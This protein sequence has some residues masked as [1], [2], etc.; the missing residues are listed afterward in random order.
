LSP[1]DFL[2]KAETAVRSARV[3]LEAD[4]PDGACNRAYYAM[5]DAAR[6]ALLTSSAPVH[7]EVARTH[8]GL[9]AAFGLHMVK[10]GVLD[11][12]LGRAFNRAQQVRM[13]ADYT[14]D[15]VDVETAGRVVEQAADF[16]S[17]IQQFSAK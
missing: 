16:V 13:I 11:A 10:S 17:R 12:E 2:A 15:P 14:G 7:A 3:L 4:D 8:G 9:I 5:F 6:A 1:A